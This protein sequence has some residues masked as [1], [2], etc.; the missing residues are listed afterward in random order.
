MILGS[1]PMNCDKIIV[2]NLQLINGCITEQ[3]NPQPSAQ[4]RALPANVRGSK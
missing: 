4:V 3:L 2:C 1:S